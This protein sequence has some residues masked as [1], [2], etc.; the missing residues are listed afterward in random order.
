M[1]DV[2]L[3][4]R[5]EELVKCFVGIHERID[6]YVVA[7]NEDLWI[8]Q[9]CAPTYE[10]VAALFEGASAYTHPDLIRLL[11]RDDRYETIR[12]RKVRLVDALESHSPRAVVE[13][14]FKH[15]DKFTAEDR[16]RS[17]LLLASELPTSVAE[18]AGEERT[19]WLDRIA[20]SFEASPRALRLQLLLAASIVGH[21]PM[22]SLLL[23]D[24]AAG[25]ELAPNIDAVEAECLIEAAMN[26]HYPIV[27]EFLAGGSFDGSKVA[28]TGVKHDMSTQE[29]VRARNSMHNRVKSDLFIPAGGRPNTIN[30]NNW[31]DYIDADGKPSSGLIVEGANLFI[32]P[33]ARQ[34]LFD[35][36]GVVI[37]KDSSANKCGVVCSSY[38]I[39]ASM[40][41]E[42]DEFLAVKDE[43][44]VEVVDKLRALARV[45]AQ[46]LFR[47]YKKDPTSALPPASERISR[48]IT[49]V[50]DAVLAHFDDVCEEDQQILFT[51]IEEG[52]V[53]ERVRAKAKEYAQATA[54]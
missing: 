4:P 34:L 36:A 3:P 22:V 53:Q 23:G 9:L 6:Y 44:V 30:E 2:R 51:L 45:E 31:R 7:G 38:E 29:G 19:E 41:L 5:A 52:V 40:L 46:L 20:D 49:R 21:E 47:E 42:T 37:V 24:I 15:L 28:S 12:D 32:T 39:V 1:N 11:Y 17:F 13:E 26:Q 33:E 50:H 35:N 18:D 48:A 10:E 16:A 14:L 43:L 27:K 8:T 54:T 25:D